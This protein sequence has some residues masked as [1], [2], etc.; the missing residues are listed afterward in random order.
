MKTLAFARDFYDLF[1]MMKQQCFEL[2]ELGEEATGTK[3]AKKS[4]KWSRNTRTERQPD[5]RPRIVGKVR[6]LLVDCGVT[7]L[8]TPY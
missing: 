1:L 6:R 4:D 2:E 5:V 8:I 7:T 3:L